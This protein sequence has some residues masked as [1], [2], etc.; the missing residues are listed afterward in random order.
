MID[1]HSHTTASDGEHSP[2]ELI[3]VAAAK[4]VT[5][6]SITDHDTLAGLA[7][8]QAAADAKGLTL[9]PGIEISA[10][11]HG[12]KEVHVLG[13]FLDVTDPTLARYADRLRADRTE[14]MEAMVAKVKGLG[15]PVTMEAV[16]KI[17][18]GA[19]LGR[20]HLAFWFVQRGY[21]AN[22]KEA[23]DRFLGDGRAAWVD[24][25]RLPM[26][27]AIALIRN[28]QGTATLAHPGTSRMERGE[29]ALM[30]QAGLSGLEALH[31]DH[32]PSVRQ[33]Y[34]QIAAELALV[35]T[36]GSDYHGPTLTPDRT[37]GCSTTPP[38]NLERLRARA[39]VL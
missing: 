5:H 4:G 16:L 17:A 18:D 21:C 2:T 19:N 20:P 27:E 33:K 13:H 32:G 9:I 6:L 38:A 25:D 8:A 30:A 37:P 10:F 39:K 11:V 29:I 28:A 35:P 14:R 34:L 31:A 22:P 26:E 7:E 12:R 15:F 1:L 24:R 36:G 23:F 3:A